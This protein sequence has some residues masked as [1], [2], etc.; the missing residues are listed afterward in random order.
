MTHLTSPR[1]K[2][3]LNSPGDAPS[4][5]TS[6]LGWGGYQAQ[7]LDFVFMG[8]PHGWTGGKLGLN[9]GKRVW[10]QTGQR[11]LRNSKLVLTELQIGMYIYNYDSGFY[12]IIGNDLER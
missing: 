10:T 1:G 5:S 4:E 7:R 8:M 3:R 2:P 6:V 11:A 9:D 12:G